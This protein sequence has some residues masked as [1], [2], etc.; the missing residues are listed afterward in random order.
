M[1]AI[2]F[3]QARAQLRL[4]DVLD[5]LGFTPS[6]RRGSAWRGPCPVHRSRRVTSRSF[7]ADV[8]K[9]LWHCFACG[10]GGNALDLWAALTAQP[11]HAAVIDL[12]TRLGQDVPWRLPRR[13]AK[14]EK[15]PMP[16][17]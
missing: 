12:C 10:A 15:R 3:R 9:D 2:D 16:E 11:L 17:S 8:G 4:A 6:V 1:P 13:V 5:L 14:K 7:A